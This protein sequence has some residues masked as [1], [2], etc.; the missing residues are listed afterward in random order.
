MVELVELPLWFIAGV[1]CWQGLHWWVCLSVLDE[2]LCLICVACAMSICLSP[3]SVCLPFSFSS[4]QLLIQTSPV[5][6]AEAIMT[7]TFS[8]LRTRRTAAS[9]QSIIVAP[10][11]L[12]Q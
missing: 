10:A 11:C 2:F 12:T 4:P 1:A 8:A 9:S 7:R 6:A 5:D 3:D